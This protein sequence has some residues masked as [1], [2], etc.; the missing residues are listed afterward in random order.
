MKAFT[1]QDE[2]LSEKSIKGLKDINKRRNGSVNF[3]KVFARWS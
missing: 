3:E 1:E 2:E